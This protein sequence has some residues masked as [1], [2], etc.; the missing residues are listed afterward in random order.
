SVREMCEIGRITG[1][2]FQVSHISSCSAF[3]N[4]EEVLDLI[5]DYRKSGVDITVDAYPYGAFSTAIGTAVFEGDFLERW[6]KD[7]YAIVLTEEPYKNVPCTEEI[8]L[9]ARKNYPKMYAVANVMNEDEVIDALKRDF[10]MV[11]SDGVLRNYSGH[12]RAAGTF[13]R[14]LGKY[15]REMGKLEFFDA[16]YKMTLFP[17]ERLRVDNFKGK[18]E[19]GYDADLVIFNRDEIIDCATFEEPRIPPKGIS[20]VIVNG[21]IAVK[22]NQIIR[23]NLG[24]YIRR[25]E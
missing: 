17:A 1:I 6:N 19:E 13:P 2:P 11:A 10:V 14:V 5:E 3:G 8:F 21:N 24:R 4:M 25:S 15:V 20:H 18:V 16:L 9:D 7:Y 23:N 12:P 22:D